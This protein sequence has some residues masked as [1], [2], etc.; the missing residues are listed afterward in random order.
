MAGV[1]VEVD[2]TFDDEVFVDAPSDALTALL[3][4]A[5]PGH[6]GL[7]CSQGITIPALVDRIAAGVVESDTRKGAAWVLSLVD[8][9]V[10]SFDY[11]D[12]PTERRSSD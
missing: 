9:D 3:A 8:G 2:P 10:V 7:V 4:L 1:P 6:V 5:K 12:D 11:Y